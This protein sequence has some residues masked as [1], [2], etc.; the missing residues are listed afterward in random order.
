MFYAKMSPQP[1]SHRAPER[2]PSSTAR[3]ARFTATLDGRTTTGRFPAAGRQSSTPR[4]DPLR[5]SV[6]LQGGVCGNC[7]AKITAGEV[8]HAPQLRS[9]NSRSRRRLRPHL[10]VRPRQRTC[11]RRLRRVTQP[12]WSPSHDQSCPDASSTDIEFASRDQISIL[13]LEPLQWSLKHAYDKRAALPEGVR[14]GGCPSDGSE[15]LS[16]RPKFPFTTKEDLRGNYPFGMFAV[17]QD[18]VSRIHA[19]SGTTA[20][21]LSSGTP[22]LTRQLGRPDRA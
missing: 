9:R 1:D 22:R 15:D 16:D 4:R 2:E 5:P 17:P 20:G 14:R 3:R 11:H 13:Q 18:K 21:R 12:S 7:R 19:S 10:P 6:R 8:G